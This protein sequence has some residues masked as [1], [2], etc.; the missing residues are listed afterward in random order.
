MEATAHRHWILG[1]VLLGSQ[2]YVLLFVF[3]VEHNK[4][5]SRYICFC[6]EAGI[7]N[8]AYKGH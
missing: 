3:E 1:M 5:D 8:G 7:V 2:R 6:G 4:T